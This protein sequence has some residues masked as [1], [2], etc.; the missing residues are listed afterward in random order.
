MPATKTKAYISG[1]S[2]SLMWGLS[3]LSIKVSVAVLPPMTL[4][5]ARFVLATAALTLVMLFQGP[6]AKGR[7]GLARLRFDG[8]D[9]PYVAGA[10]L[11][12]V[13][14]YFLCENNGVKL[15]T[16]AESSILIGTIP[17]LTMLADRLFRGTRLGGIQY[18]GA[19]LSAVGIVL[20]VAESLRL[21]STPLGYVFMLGAALSWVLYSFVTHPIIEKYG[22][23]EITFWQSLF[24]GLGFIPF[25]LFEKTDWARV[26]PELWLHVAYL[27][28]VCSALGYLLYVY[29]MRAL[30]FGVASV[31]INLIPVVSVASSF[32]L[33]NERLTL[34][35]IAGAVVVIVG[36][37]LATVAKKNSPRSEGGRSAE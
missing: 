21:T 29:N 37:Y 25:A 32:V 5:L 18:G 33:L 3:F 13:T 1:V 20:I 9:F 36:V 4:G 7:R 26:G 8:K 10:G 24:G 34:W 31:F 12:G 35:Q 11:V 14:L 22:Q 30:G 28:L 19:V 23:L 2:L 15:L 6:D 16:A 17:V 27:G